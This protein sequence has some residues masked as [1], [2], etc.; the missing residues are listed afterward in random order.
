MK[1]RSRD[2]V[3][4]LLDAFH[5]IPWHRSWPVFIIVAGVMALL[6]RAA[7]NSAAA[8]SMYPPQVPSPAG[9]GASADARPASYGVTATGREAADIAKEHHSHEGGI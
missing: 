1:W 2:G 6:Q 7:Y 3:L 8:P 4:L 5:L 9:S